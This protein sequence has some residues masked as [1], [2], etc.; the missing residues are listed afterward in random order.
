M[1]W[2][3]ARFHVNPKDWRPVKWPPPGPCWKTGAT[4]LA[5]FTPGKS[6]VVAYVKDETQIIE[7]WP[8]ATDIEAEPKSEIVYTDRFPRPEWW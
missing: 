5:D 4:V 2:L 3:R 1:T 7:F 8:D 6:I